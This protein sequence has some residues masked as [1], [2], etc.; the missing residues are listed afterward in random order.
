MN[1][2]YYQNPTFPGA[3][4]PNNYTDTVSQKIF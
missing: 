3:Q 4:N 2:T 1:G